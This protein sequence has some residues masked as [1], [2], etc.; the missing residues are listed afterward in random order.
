MPGLPSRVPGTQ[1]GRAD[2]RFTGLESLRSPGRTSE[3]LFLFEISTKR[4]GRLR[5]IAQALDLSVQAI[6]LLFRDAVARGW[7]ER[8]DGVFRP[9]VEGTEHLHESLEKLSADLSDRERKLAIVRR[10]RALARED[11][12]PGVR[13][14]LSMEGGFLVAKKGEA[15]DSRGKVLR[16]ARKGGLVEV[17][18]LAGIL[19]LRPAGVRV[20]V[21]L[22]ALL[23]PGGD[24]SA[25]REELPSNEETLL[26]AEGLEAY[27]L[28]RELSGRTPVRFGTAPAAREASQKGVPSV[29][30]VT[31]EL[32]PSLLHQLAQPGPTPPLS[33]QTLPG[34]RRARP[35]PGRGK[36]P[37]RASG[38]LRGARGGSR[39]ASPPRS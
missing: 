38:V 10:C 19:P 14:V 30:V 31:E 7:V 39:P 18:E 1:A 13:V 28:V 27:H 5:S 16:G 11:L 15:G 26:A 34:P 37:V 12:A 6:S 23:A 35:G 21:L 29:L 33:I 3:L 22:P 8:L 20:L 17:G 4:H 2:E 25:L 24:R 36:G 32:L 9:T